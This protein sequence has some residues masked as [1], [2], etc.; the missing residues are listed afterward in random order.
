MGLVSDKQ[1]LIAE[2]SHQINNPLT[3]IRNSLY[4][5]SC[6]TD[7]PQLLSYLTL[8]DEEITAITNILRAAR[9]VIEEMTEAASQKNRALFSTRSAAA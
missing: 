9:A 5:A 2:L 4:L 8:A 1:R 7:D 6:Q 3:A